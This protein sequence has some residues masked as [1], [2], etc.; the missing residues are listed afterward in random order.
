M[1]ALVVVSNCEEEAAVLAKSLDM[2]TDEVLGLPQP[3][4]RKLVE[5]FIEAGTQP[6]QNPT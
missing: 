2:T 6:L 3:D 5:A 1:I 4:Y